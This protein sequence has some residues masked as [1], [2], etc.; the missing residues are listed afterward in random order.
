MVVNLPEFF[1]ACSPS[2]TLVTSHA[3]DSPYYID[4]SE[5]RGRQ[6]IQKLTWT[7]TRVSPNTPTCQLL[8]GCG[9]CGKSTELRRL[10]EE[11]KKQGFHVIYLQCSGQQ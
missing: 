2:R 6:I 7:I 1:K 4:F 11:L 3:E 5:V 8:T 10:K 9:G